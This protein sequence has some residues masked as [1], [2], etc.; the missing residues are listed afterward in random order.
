M[1]VF[2]LPPQLAYIARQVVKDMIYEEA[3]CLLMNHLQDT[4]KVRPLSEQQ[5]LW[6]E[7]FFFFLITI[8]HL[9]TDWF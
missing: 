3:Q 5:N 9:E 2:P 1:Q 4:D 7:L 8:G 6:T